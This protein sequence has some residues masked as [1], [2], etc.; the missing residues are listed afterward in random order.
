MFLTLLTQNTC[1]PSNVRPGISPLTTS[2]NKQGSFAPNCQSLSS[3]VSW[4]GP[5]TPSFIPSSYS[6]TRDF[7]ADLPILFPS[8]PLNVEDS[9]ECMCKNVSKNT[10]LWKSCCHSQW[11][12]GSYKKDHSLVKASVFVIPR[13]VVQPPGRGLVRRDSPA[14]EWGLVRKGSPAAEWGLVRRGSPAAEWGLVRRGSSSDRQSLFWSE[15][16]YNKPPPRL[17]GLAY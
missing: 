2:L 16:S 11:I 7:S 3:R 13:N 14:A 1:I 9:A 17:P 15:I 12:T 4:D 6:Q 8:H 5:L 10:E